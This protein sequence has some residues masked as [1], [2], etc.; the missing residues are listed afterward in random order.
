MSA[1]LPVT[2]R[3]SPT[4]THCRSLAA[5]SST[6]RSPFVSCVRCP[7]QPIRPPNGPARVAFYTHFAI[8]HNTRKA[9]TAHQNSFLGIYSRLG[10]SPSLPLSEPDLCSAVAEYART[11]KRTTVAGFVSALAYRADELGHGTLPRGTAFSRMLQGIH[12]F[13]ADQVTTPKTALTLADML[14]LYRFIDHSTFEGARDWC[15]CSLAFF[16]LL[17]VN[18]YMNGHLHHTHVG[19][20]GAGVWI[21]VRYSKTVLQPTRIDIAARTDCL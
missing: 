17:R 20:S 11:H 8:R 13:H 14:A 10:I 16:G 7:Q 3:A 2:T 5:G 19:F 6:A 18:E 21:I 9:Y 4:Q 15:A 12:N 1:A